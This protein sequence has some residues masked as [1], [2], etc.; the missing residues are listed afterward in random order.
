MKT[1]LWFKKV[2]QLHAILYFGLHSEWCT[3]VEF[4]APGDAIHLHSRSELSQNKITWR[5]E[6]L[7]DVLSYGSLIPHR[8]YRSMRRE[9]KNEHLI[10]T[11]GH[12]PKDRNWWSWMDE[13]ARDSVSW[14]GEGKEW[15]GMDVID[16][17]TWDGK[18][19]DERLY[20]GR[21]RMRRN[22]MRW[23]EMS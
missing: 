20:M 11:S 10:T 6:F 4:L 12:E 19:C 2:Q 13:I 18:R 15:N 7:S 8:D 1:Y 22:E 3:Y 5:S 21:L 9:L 17:M 23:Y 14:V 16:G